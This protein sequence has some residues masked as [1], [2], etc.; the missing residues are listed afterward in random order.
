MIPE[1][2][3][4]IPILPSCIR[5]ILF[6]WHPWVMPELPEVE[7]TRRYLADA[8]VGRTLG[9]PVL[10]ASRVFRR[11][12]V[13]QEVSDRLEG[14]V[15]RTVDRVGKCLIAELGEGVFW[16]MHLGMSGRLRI[17]DPGEAE[18][19][20]TH[21]RV[22]L[23]GDPAIEVRFIDPRTF[24]FVAALTSNEAA[25]L[26]GELGRDALNDLPPSAELFS[27]FASRSA[28]IKAVLLDQ[29][30]VAGLGNIYSDEV[31]F[32]AGI[33][34]A[35]PACDLSPLEVDDLRRAIHPVL[36]AGIAE[37]GTSLD[38]LAY[39]L[40]DGR[41]GDYLSRLEVYGRQG[42]ECRKCGTIITKM[43]LA[44]RSTHLCPNC[45]R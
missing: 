7:I 19:I 38:D 18:I 15:V 45:Q 14:R 32:S 33:H 31:L 21:F 28:P 41:A 42:L 26:Q 16:V 44:Q 25:A 8:V 3:S 23:V 5:M 39:L 37:G 30:V 12:Q 35:R 43:I 11:N 22:T 13:P 2:S 6:R 4:A 24:G 1:S 10:G 29:R 36:E 40:P 34:P 9:R 17:C 20:H 27:L